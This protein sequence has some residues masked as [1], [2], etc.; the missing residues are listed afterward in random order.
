M[1][2]KDTIRKQMKQCRR[3]LSEEECREAGRKTAENLLQLPELREC[4]TVFAYLSR[5]GEVPTL[6]LAVKLL[7]TGRRVAV[8]KVTGD[9]RMEF[10]EIHSLAECSAGAYGIL[11]PET[12]VILYPE[13]GAHPVI[14]L[15]GLAFTARGERLGYGGGYYD[16]YLKRYPEV[17]RAALAYEFSLLPELPSEEHDERADIL[18]LP[19]R[20]IRTDR[21]NGGSYDRY[22]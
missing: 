5:G 16:R 17:F 7:E 11:E 2:E 12:E 4:R 6:E 19:E 18:I 10:F 9:G 21:Q 13:A 3:A 22:L 8:P 15:P 20:V 1:E 14:L